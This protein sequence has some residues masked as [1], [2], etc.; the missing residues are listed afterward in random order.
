M[1][2]DHLRIHAQLM[3]VELLLLALLILAQPVAL[4]GKVNA[5]TECLHL[6]QVATVA[7]VV[8]VAMV[9]RTMAMAAATAV[10][11]DNEE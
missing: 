2:L 3:E 6:V 10:A 5:K 1:A 11:T 7:M 8:M 4:V 9:P